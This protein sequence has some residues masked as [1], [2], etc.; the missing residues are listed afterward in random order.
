MLK[1]FKGFKKINNEVSNEQVI[2]NVN[3][4]NIVPKIEEE[5]YIEKELDYDYIFNKY[6]KNQVDEKDIVNKQNLIIQVAN[7]FNVDLEP[8][9]YDISS[10]V[11]R[12][13]FKIG[14]G[15]KV[16]KIIKLQDEFAIYLGFASNEISI[17]TVPNEFAIGIEIPNRKSSIV[18]M[19]DTIY[20]DE[21]YKSD[22]T[23]VLGQ[24]INSKFKYIDLAKTP[25]LLVAGTT[26]SGKSV[27]LNTLISCLLMKQTEVDLILIDPKK[28]EFK[29]Y[30]NVRNLLIPVVTDIENACNTL[31][32]LLQ[33]MDYRYQL[34]E[35]YGVKN[36]D[37]YNKTKRMRKI[38]VVIDE[39][40][41][42]MMQGGKDIEYCVARLTQLSRACGIHLVIATQRPT[43]D[44]ITGLIKSNMPSRISFAVPSA[45]DSK[46]ILDET[47]AENLLGHGDMLCK[48]AGERT[49]RLSGCFIGEDEIKRLVGALNG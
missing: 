23:I 5:V 28:V 41:D 20:D 14:Q 40:A 3:Q 8:K 34:F 15:V 44:V 33:E 39:F 31:S 26:G 22:T 10:N 42:L 35:K 4:V 45:V 19:K 13:K 38:V 24:D 36:I 37:E 12:I 17:T 46:V 1:L 32:W 47:G 6:D 11:I 9:G 25:H 21:F 27:F 30:N 43:T 49:T 7:N 16:N 48:I 18:S 29:V 2:Y